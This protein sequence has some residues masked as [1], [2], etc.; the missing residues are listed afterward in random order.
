MIR[1]NFNNPF[2]GLR[3]FESDES[4]LFFGRQTQ[5]MEILQRLHYYHFVAITGGSG[6]GKSSL[7]RAGVIPSLKAGYLVLSRDQWIIAIMKPGQSPIRN[8][9]NAIFEQSDLKHVGLSSKE[10]EK[11]ISKQG[12]DA[13]LEFLKSFIRS[14]SN[15]LLL[16]DQF[17]ELFRFSIDK[18]DF[19]KTDEA[20]SFVNILLELSRQTE[21]PV[22]VM[23]TMRSDF[24][25]DCEQFYGLP[26]AMNQSQYI[27]P[28]LNR[29]QLENII[30]GPIRLYSGNIN[31]A[32]TA[33]LLND[34]QLVKDELPL[35]QHA[36]MRIWDTEK[37]IDKNGELDLGDYKRIGGI[38]KALSNH[39][40]E[41]LQ[42]MSAAELNLTKK[43]FQALTGI[44]ENGRKIRRPARLNE[45]QAVSGADKEIILSIINRFIEGNKC[46]LVINKLEN[47][48]DLLIDIS[49]ESLIRQ[50]SILNAW[51]DEEAESGKMFLRLSESARLYSENK[52]DLLAGNELHQILQWFYSFSP[53]KKWTQRYDSGYEKNIQYLKE[54][55]KEEQKQRL[56]KLRN[57]RLLI[58]SLI[59]IIIIISGFA[60][61]IY[62]NNI[63][64]KKALALNYWKSSQSARSD[65]NF[66][67]ALHLVAGAAVASNDQEL[68]QKF[69]IDGEAY[70]PR[71]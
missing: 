34:A 48:N 38:E 1:T 11:K 14:N 54:S 8:L 44:D 33:R 51:V 35:L 19:N 71:T 6:S 5:T 2:V 66:L 47:E 24:I 23:T 59:F 45:L 17:E 57:R 50:W 10:L 63:R 29:I 16:V 9:V 28:R 31:P 68:I 60:Y 40:D 62:Q 43:I 69:L 64:N 58:A 41:A 25:G 46:F 30:E 3:P 18:K 52:K 12:T 61:S 70:L 36:L 42:G 37:I 53:G 56:I 67:D 4:L 39:A 22:Y 20:I 7:I 65:N 49:H 55:E 26:E 13:V 15:L 32:L 21:L 27:V